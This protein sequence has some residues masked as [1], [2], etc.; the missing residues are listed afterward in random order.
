MNRLNCRR[1]ETTQLPKSSADA[2]DRARGFTL[3]ELMVTIALMAIV[4]GLAAPSFITFQRNSDLTA[5][6][7]SFV[8]A[9]SAARAEAMKRQLDAYVVPCNTPATC[10]FTDDWANGWRVFV[11]AVVS[12]TPNPNAATNII[13]SQHD[14][15]TNVVPTG[16]D[17][18]DGRYIGFSGSGFLKQLNG[19]FGVNSML[20]V[21]HSITHEVRCLI[22]NP[23]GRVR[24]FN[25]AAA[26]CDINET[27]S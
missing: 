14:A 23:S 21:T 12:A 3:I 16:L 6:A 7:N 10:T 2:F 26:G 17:Q 25:P 13:V 9:V 24:V 4:L 20:V 8:A 19:A 1:P 18:V 15:P 22:V 5:T 11:P 27:F